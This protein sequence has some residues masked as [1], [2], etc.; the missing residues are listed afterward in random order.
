MSMSLSSLDPADVEAK[1][2]PHCTTLCECSQ[3]AR[4]S[5]P[6][7]DRQQDTRQDFPLSDLSLPSP[8]FLI[9]CAVANNAAT[10]NFQALVLHAVSLLHD[11]RGGK[12]RRSAANAL[13]LLASVLNH[14]A[15]ANGSNTAIVLNSLFEITP[16]LAIPQELVTPGESQLLKVLIRRVLS[17][18]VDLDAR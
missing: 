11:A 5:R 8:W 4:C 12:N 13:R 10:H 3:T 7:P 2:N 17:T 1:L 18:I 16:S 6:A 15:S 9:P 14:A